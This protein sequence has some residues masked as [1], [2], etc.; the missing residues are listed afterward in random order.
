MEILEFVLVY[1]AYHSLISYPPQH[2]QEQQ[3]QNGKCCMGPGQSKLMLEASL[4]KGTLVTS[5]KVPAFAM[6]LL[7][8]VPAILLGQIREAQCCALQ[9]DIEHRIW[10]RRALSH[11]PSFSPPI[12]KKCLSPPSS[13]PSTHQH[14]PVHHLVLG[15]HLQWWGGI[16]LPTGTLGTRNMHYSPFV[17]HRVLRPIG[18]GHYFPT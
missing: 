9:P 8:S 3:C 5:S 4:G 10:Q 14:L 12:P 15:P 17:T 11:S 1:S 6:G 2:P 18:M 7:E 13:Q 16:G